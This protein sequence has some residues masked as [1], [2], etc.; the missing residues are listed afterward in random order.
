MLLLINDTL[1][2]SVRNNNKHVQFVSECGCCDGPV[3][4]AVLTM[5]VK[6]RN[7]GDFRACLLTGN[8]QGHP[9][10]FDLSASPSREETNDL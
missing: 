2:E 3:S 1:I 4:A 8:D 6:Y 10:S 9:I 5:T 7:Y